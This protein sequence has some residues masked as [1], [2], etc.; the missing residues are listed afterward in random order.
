MSKELMKEE[1]KVRGKTEKGLGRERGGKTEMER[2]CLVP[3]QPDQTGIFIP[4]F[5]SRRKLMF[6][7]YIMSKIRRREE[8]V[9]R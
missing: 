1:E 7:P 6:S 8:D 2:W 4:L 5:L 9:D 3:R